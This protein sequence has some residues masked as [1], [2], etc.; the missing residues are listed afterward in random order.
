MLTEICAT[1][2]LISPAHAGA[3]GLAGAAAASRVIE[4]GLQIY[5]RT[6][7]CPRPTIIRSLTSSV[8]YVYMD[9]RIVSDFHFSLPIQSLCLSNPNKIYPYSPLLSP[10][11]TLSVI[12]CLCTSVE[13]VPGVRA[14]VYRRA[15]GCLLQ[16][17]ILNKAVACA[18][19]NFQLNPYL[20]SILPR[21]RSARIFERRGTH[22][23]I[24]YFAAINRSSY[25]R[26]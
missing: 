9:A 18:N 3:G 16:H 11:R 19:S 13:V 1:C 4:H 26:E 7:S 12:H 17:S 21:R 2:H 15:H 8:S 5:V 25:R 22:A 23:H 24:R 20:W 14:C 6:G 10:E